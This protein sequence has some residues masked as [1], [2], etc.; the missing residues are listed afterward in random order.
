MRYCRPLPLRCSARRPSLSLQILS[1][2]PS[3]LSRSTSIGPASPTRAAAHAPLPPPSSF[4]SYASL[5]AHPPPRPPA[6]PPP[7]AGP[8]S[9]HGRQHGVVRRWR[10]RDLELPSGGR[11]PDPLPLWHL[12]PSSSPRM[13]GWWL[14]EGPPACACGG[15]SGWPYVSWE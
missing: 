13:R 7:A 8:G 3:P 6:P 4:P 1:R 5:A 10:F 2:L 15:G 12:P 14:E 9:R 11:P